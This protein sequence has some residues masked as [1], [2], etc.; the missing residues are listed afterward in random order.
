MKPEKLDEIDKHNFEE[1]K[2]AFG[3][4]DVALVSSYDTQEKRHV[5]LICVVQTDADDPK[6]YDVIP[7]AVLLERDKVDR[8][9]PPDGDIPKGQVTR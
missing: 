4:S 9:L 2:R 8:Y 1:L 7:V 6:M 5:A 3:N